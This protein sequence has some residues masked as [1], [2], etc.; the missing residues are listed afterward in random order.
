MVSEL[1]I[2]YYTVNYNDLIKLKDYASDY[3]IILCDVNKYIIDNNYNLINHLKEMNNIYVIK[4]IILSDN[5]CS[6]ISNIRICNNSRDDLII[7]KNDVIYFTFYEDDS[8]IILLKKTDVIKSIIREN[9]KRIKESIHVMS[10]LY[11]FRNKI[12]NNYGIKD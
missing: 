4:D 10:S 2:P 12:L 8:N 6:I 3:A 11:R 1:N 9:K 5:K 7:Y